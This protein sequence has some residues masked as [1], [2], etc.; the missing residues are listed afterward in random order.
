MRRTYQYSV[1]LVDKLEIMLPKPIV[2][3]VPSLLGPEGTNCAVEV[4]IDPACTRQVIVQTPV[5]VQRGIL[6]LVCTLCN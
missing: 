4:T 1:D 3:V 2:S 6:T 5:P